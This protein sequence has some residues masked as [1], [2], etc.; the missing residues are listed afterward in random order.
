MRTQNST[1]KGSTVQTALGLAAAST[2]LSGLFL[3]FFGVIYTG[4]GTALF[5]FLS[6][7]FLFLDATCAGFGTASSGLPGFLFRRISATCAGLAASSTGRP[8]EGQARPRKQGG[9]TY[10]RKGLLHVFKIH[11]SPPK[12]NNRLILHDNSSLRNS[13]KRRPRSLLLYLKIHQE[14]KE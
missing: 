13:I 6:L 14:K 10:A 8:C 11:R 2:T 9:H 12:I 1:R 3:L 5:A 4:L 7:F